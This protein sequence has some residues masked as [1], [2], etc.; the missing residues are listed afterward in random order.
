MFTNHVVIKDI[1]GLKNKIESLIQVQSD[2]LIS[3]KSKEEYEE[4]LKI[5]D[6]FRNKDYGYR[7]KIHHNIWTWYV[8]VGCNS[9][10]RIIYQK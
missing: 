1:K 8:P 4:C 7:G 3:P 6:K 2:I 5:V 9:V 10:V